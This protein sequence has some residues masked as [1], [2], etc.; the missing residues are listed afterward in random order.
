MMIQY[1]VDE[2]MSFQDFL[3][4]TN[5][6]NKLTKSIISQKLITVNLFPVNYVQ[7]VSKGDTVSFTIPDEEI[8]QS[9]IH[10]NIP[11]DIRYED[12][13]LLIINKSA[14]MPVM[15]TKS[16]PNHTLSNAL[17]YYY[18]NH[19]INSKIHLV[20]RL[21]KDTSGLMIVA[22]NRYVKYLLS[23][24]L[25]QKISREYI[26]VVEGILKEKSGTIA[27][28]IG[29]D[30]PLEMKRSVMENGLEAITHYEVMTFG[31]NYTVLSVRLE[32]GRTHQIRV[33]LSHISHPIIGD[34]L[35]Q[36]AYGGELLLCSHKLQFFHPITNELI[37]IKIDLPLSFHSYITNNKKGT[38][39]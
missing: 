30:D 37:K 19:Q 21:D 13:Y 34:K 10:E 26:C 1:K 31:D 24:N 33:H 38:D 17:C 9:I 32:T 16:H 2:D 5:L 28:P 12:D 4:S 14:K 29:K 39:N 15:V 3:V 23:E 36:S 22:K 35:Y 27:L 7:S 20:N 8:D 11:L 18:Q 6:P 25:K